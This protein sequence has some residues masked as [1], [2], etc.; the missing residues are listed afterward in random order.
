MAQ[1]LTLALVFAINLQVSGM[2]MAGVEEG[3]EAFNKRQFVEARKELTPLAEEGLPEAMAYLGEMLMRGQGG[4]RDE[5]KARDYITRAQAAGNLRATYQL[6]LMTLEGNLVTRD[7]AKGV[8]LIKQAGD[9]AY[10][11]AQ[12]LMGIWIASGAQGYAKDEAVALS[13]FKQAADQKDPTGMY[14]LG[15]FA[16]TALGGVPQDNLQAL[17]QYKRASELGHAEATA[18][19]GRFYAL[20][21]GVAADGPEA[22]K[23]LQR[24]VTVGSSSAYLWMG[25]VYEFGRGGVARNPALAHAWYQAMPARAPALTLK[26]ALDGK[27]RLS[28]TLSPQELAD[29][30]KLAKA[31]VAQ[32][33]IATLPSMAGNPGIAP[34]IR[35]GVYGSGVV[36]SAAGDIVSNEHVIN[37]CANIRAQPGAWPV[38]L[39]AK[40]AKNDLA[41]LRLQGGSI[42]PVRLRSGRGL[43]LGDDVVAIGYPL[44]GT[45]SSGPIVTMGIVNAMSG[46]NNDTSAFQ[47]SATVQPGSS[48]GP[49]FDRSGLLV[50]VVRARLLS[51]NAANA[52]NVNFG[53]NLAT[54]QGF[55]DAH[56]VDYALGAVSN[57]PSSVGDMVA[58]AQK[59]AVQLECY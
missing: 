9:Q 28:K 18:A 52:Q 47:M 38:K 49:V 21:K 31:V 12:A 29:A 23:W 51:T 45:L 58:A 10:A 56:S 41:L 25:S 26:A 7:A 50:G 6:G 55:L 43:R 35:R 13:W 1:R 37:N 22:L 3:R 16:E 42:A 27:E 36:V 24:G 19:V 59:S 4:T 20:G 5:L 57:N 48:G 34:T 2:A 8:A 44:R 40:D 53:I 32:T 33:I 46:A 30:D 11:P 17:D 15:Y 54:V 39:V 14:W